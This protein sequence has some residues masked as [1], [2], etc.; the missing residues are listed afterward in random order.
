MM[1]FVREFLEKMTDKNI[2]IIP[3]NVSWNWS[4]DYLNQ[5]AF[6]LAKLGYVVVC[7]LHA[8]TLYLKDFLNFKKRP[9]FLQRYSRNIY[10]ITPRFLIPLRRFKFIESINVNLNVILLRL[11]TEVIYITQKCKNKIFWLFDPNLLSIYYFFSKKYYLL[12]DCVDFFAVGSKEEI[13]RTNQCEKKLCKNADLVVANS[14]VLQKNLQKYRLNVPLIPQG[15]RA[16]NFK[17]IKNKY[18]DLNLKK[19]VIGFVGGINNRLDTSILLPLIKNNP[20]WNFVLW[21]PIQK[22]FNTGSDRSGQISQILNLP[23]VKTGESRDKQEIPGLV[24]Q[25]DV[26][27]IPYDISQ[28]FNKYC[29]PMKLFEYFYLGKPIVST[30][31]YELKRFPGLVMIGKNYKEWQIILENLLDRKW[32]T[33]NIKNQ[34]KFAVENSWE[35]KVSMIVG[36]INL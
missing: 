25:F 23:N 20:K 16:D 24:S 2:I 7:Y 4:T 5:T 12:Y 36:L 26:G 1:I 29:Y 28:D 19:P 34:L 35:N 30:G 22:D 13:Q 9:K 31:I 17:V 27:I 11:I 21:G 3:F 6:E 33:E 10:I 14:K 8:D 15:F 18:I 32:P